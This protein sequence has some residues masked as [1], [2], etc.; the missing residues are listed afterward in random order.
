MLDTIK[1]DSKGVKMVAHRGVSG[2]EKENT[3]PAFVLAGN[4]SYYG[5]ECDVHVTADGKYVICHDDD[6][7]RVTGVK[8]MVIEKTNFADIVAVPIL[9]TDGVTKRSDL[10]FPTLEDYIKICRKYNKVAVLELKNRIVK[11]HV[12]GIIEQ[13]RS[14][15]WLERTTFISFD[16]DNMV[17]LRAL[18][19]TVT[20]QYLHCEINEEIIDFATK[21]NVDLDI[22]FWNLTAEMVALA[23]EKGRLVNCWTV[24]KP[25]DAEKVIALGVDMITSNILE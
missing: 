6:V 2:V 21:N 10:V 17:D 3:C 5:I 1:I 13:I 18:E 11:E 9:D 25:E 16:R 14:L 7:E 20:A 24:D 15:G 23:H 22:G 19:P 8:D 4:K 12:K